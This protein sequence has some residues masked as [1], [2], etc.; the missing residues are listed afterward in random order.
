MDRNFIKQKEMV[1]MLFSELVR[2]RYNDL[3]SSVLHMSNSKHNK[4]VGD[5][6]FREKKI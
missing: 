1:I 4:K 6:L 5:I 3:S 2:A